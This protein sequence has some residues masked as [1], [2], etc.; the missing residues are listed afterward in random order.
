MQSSLFSHLTGWFLACQVGG[1]FK[2][3][4][5]LFTGTPLADH[6][7]YKCILNSGSSAVLFNFF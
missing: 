2:F 1:A 3:S 5:G 7:A 4:E 6:G